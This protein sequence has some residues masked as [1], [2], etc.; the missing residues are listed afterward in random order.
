M[1]R[2]IHILLIAI[3]VLSTIHYSPWGA[4]ST[5]NAASPVFHY[6]GF[7]AW[8]GVS[9]FRLTE[10][11]YKNELGGTGG[12]AFQYK[13]EQGHFR[14]MLG[15]DAT[16][17]GSG[18]LWSANTDIPILYPDPSMTYHQT[19]K[20][21]DERQHSIEVGAKAMIGATFGPA[22]L[23]IGARA[24]VPV[25]SQFKRM[26]GVERSITDTKTIDNYT[27]MPTHGLVSG[28]EELKGTLELNINPQACF[29]LGIVLDQRSS[30]TLAQQQ[31]YNY[32]RMRRTHVELAAYANCGVMTYMAV[33]K[34][35]C[36]PW[37]AGLKLNVYFPTTSSQRA[38]VPRLKRTHYVAPE[39]STHTSVSKVHMASPKG[40]TK[41]MPKIALQYKDKTIY[42]GDKIVLNNLYF[43]SDKAVV[44]GESRAALNE[45]AKFMKDNPNLTLTLIGHTDNTNTANYNMKLSE[46]RVKAVKKEL[47]N[48]GVSANRITTIG[49]GQT[50]PVAENTTEEGK[51][52]NR[53]VEMVFDTEK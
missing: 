25:W 8:G 33:D 36:L 48:R 10:T 21:I 41:E 9:Q 46:N 43:D 34:G 16:Y 31:N 3:A 38:M 35:M 30:Y 20:Y 23:L 40:I 32:M 44:R 52:Q 15:A 4:Q 50:E 39:I 1:K 12:L 53:R 29:E 19:Y 45:L 11:E 18:L 14:F 24:G 13:L 6:V 7:S 37:N 42:T 28:T 49:K 17:A 2:N 51:Q 27:N 5:I 22:Y 47:V 26:Y